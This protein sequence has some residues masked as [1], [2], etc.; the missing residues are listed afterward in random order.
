VMGAQHPCSGQ[1]AAA[2][3]LLAV[4]RS[5]TSSPG[6]D[7][8][9]PIVDGPVRGVVL[10]KINFKGHVAQLA[11]SLQQ[12]FGKGGVKRVSCPFF[13]PLGRRR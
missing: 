12:R 5:K 2:R 13:A 10:Q 3:Q 7:R 4:A 1:T 9:R 8:I 6:N 11:R